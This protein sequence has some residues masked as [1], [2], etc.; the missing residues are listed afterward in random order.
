[1]EKAPVKKTLKQRI[2]NE[3]LHY[4]HG[5]R[6]L[7]IDI[8]VSRKLIWRILNGKSLTRREHRLLVRTTA[9]MF[10]LL[11]FSVFIIVPFMELL[12]P[13]AIKLFPGML[14]STFQTA[15]EKED[16]LKQSLKVCLLYLIYNVNNL[17]KIEINIQFYVCTND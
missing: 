3:L 9:D 1:M 10:R 11:P 16:K 14:P 17:E 4:Y 12:L 13:V 2:V 5:F 8:N 6:L 15:T 7:F